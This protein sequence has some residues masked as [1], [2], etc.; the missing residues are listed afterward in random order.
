MLACSREPGG[1]AHMRIIVTL[2]CLFIFAQPALSAGDDFFLVA[3][4]S[5]KCAQVNGG[6]LDNG[7]SISQW[8][9]VAQ[10]NVVW[11]KVDV[12]DG[13]FYL[14]AKHS[15]KCAQVNGA[16]HVNG[17]HVTQWDCLDQRNVKWRARFAGGVYVYL[18]NMESGKCM[19]VD[20]ASRDNR[21]N[22]SQWD[23]LDQGNVKWKILATS[24]EGSNVAAANALRDCIQMD[25]LD[26]KISG[27][28]DT[29]RLNP[30]SARAYNNRAWAYFK[31]G[32]AVQGL[33]DAERSLALS[34]NNPFALDTRGHIFE[35]RFQN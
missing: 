25:D 31:M 24:G 19:Q 14:K 13:Y 10:A 34:V 3:K 29:I 32:K 35:G 16:S 22:I 26:R 6:S 9:C 21:A 4:H 15:G 5:G 8:D 28:T 17:A 30:N 27:C 20:A 33:P 12:G 23:C 18:E 1:V 11:Q 2:M 7:A